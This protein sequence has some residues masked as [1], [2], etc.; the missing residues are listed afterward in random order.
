MNSQKSSE[1][2]VN[3]KVVENMAA[4]TVKDSD[5]VASE[6]NDNIPI[7]APRKYSLNINK[8]TEGESLGSTDGNSD[9]SSATEK[10]TCGTTQYSSDKTEREVDSNTMD[11]QF[12]AKQVATQ[13]KSIS[14]TSLDEKGFVATASDLHSAPF[15]VPAPRKVSVLSNSGLPVPAPRKISFSTHD[16]DAGRPKVPPRKKILR[17]QKWGLETLFFYSTISVSKTR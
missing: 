8:K 2:L 5:N 1:N 10:Q 14:A 13:R 9:Q 6:K 3:E 16:F 15:P 7:P 4:S 17:F 12:S 11:C